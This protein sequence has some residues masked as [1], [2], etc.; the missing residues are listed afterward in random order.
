MKKVIVLLVSIFLL[1]GCSG[2]KEGQNDLL[3][4]REIISGKDYAFLANI[5]ADFGENTYD[6]KLDCHFDAAGSM[7]FS[8]VSPDT[9][10]GITGNISATG[11][12]LTFDDKAVA[13]YLLAD[14]IISPVSAPWLAMKGIRSGFVSSWG[15]E[16]GGKVFTIEDILEGTNVTFRVLIG[17]DLQI[18]SAEI[19]WEDRCI[20]SLTVEDFR[21]L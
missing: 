11:G 18:K 2:T 13:F 14:G 12:E 10:L 17:K 7:T 6:F 1:T 5:H 8:I 16:E 19:I 15:E 20:L 4:L 9:I 3:K 21:Y